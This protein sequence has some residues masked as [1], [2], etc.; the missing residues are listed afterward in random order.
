MIR[1]FSATYFATFFF[2]GF[3]FSLS[4]IRCPS[5]GGIHDK[6][7]EKKESSSLQRRKFSKHVITK[8]ARRN[9]NGKSFL[10]L[11]YGLLPP[12]IFPLSYFQMAVN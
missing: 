10:C 11:R 7:E 12:L 8:E 9:E 6:K 5:Q 2:R 4:Q 3:S 1:S